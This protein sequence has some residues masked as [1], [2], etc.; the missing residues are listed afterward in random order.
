[1]KKIT[2]MAMG[3]RKGQPN[4]GRWVK[5]RKS[6]HLSPCKKGLKK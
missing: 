1:M 2:W 3:T 5:A 6:S 4:N